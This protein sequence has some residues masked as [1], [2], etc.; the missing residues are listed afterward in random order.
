M[1]YLCLM[2]VIFGT[3]TAIK[4]KIEKKQQ[5]D[6]EKEFCNGFII[7]RRVHNKGAIL[8]L[9]EKHG[10]IVKVLSLVL[11]LLFFIPFIIL[12]PKEGWV[13]EKLGFSSLLGGA[14]S[15]VYDRLK[16]G[17]VVDYFS[18]SFL[19]KIVF[20]LG[21]LFIFIGLVLVAV[22]RWKQEK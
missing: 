7:I 6:L 2:A 8:H 1:K 4:N 18:F 10:N 13:L 12:I 21:D 17:Y 19:K 14:A 16:R 20:N 9:L 3:D 5:S 15:N 11:L 22:A